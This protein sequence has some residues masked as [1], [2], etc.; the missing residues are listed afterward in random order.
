[1]WTVWKGTGFELRVAELF[2][3]KGYRVTHNVRMTGRSGA[4]HHIGT[5][6]QFEAPLHTSTVIV[7]AKSHAL[8]VSKAAVTDLIHVQQDLSADRAVFATTGGFT[9]GATQT[10]RQYQN[11]EL[12]DGAKMTSVLGTARPDADAGGGQVQAGSA[13]MVR[14]EVTPEEMQRHVDEVAEKRSRR[15]EVGE[16]AMAVTKFLYPY[17]D[18]GA[19]VKVR[20]TESTGW[21]SSE[22]V[23]STVSRRIGVDAR[24]GSIIQVADDGI[25]Y[26]YFY[27]SRLSGDEIR[28]LRSVAKGKEFE[29]GDLSTIGWTA[30][31]RNKAIRGLAERGLLA[32][33]E[34][35]TYVTRAEYP[36]DPSGFEGLADRHQVTEATADDRKLEASHTPADVGTM[37]EGLWP[38]V[39]VR[40]VDLVYYP[41]YM[42]AYERS[43]CST[44]CEIRDG[45]C[46]ER[47]EYLEESVSEDEVRGGDG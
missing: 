17:Y 25:S 20:R 19:D 6:A 36:S 24:M 15:G 34:W 8:N 4:V 29:K 43:D 38:G 33:T 32:G 39:R 11:V 10:A 47:N 13:M 22:E 18:V 27:L 14:F 7:E 42:A 1:M 44:R 37:I 16:R 40:A 30:Q 26:R 31:R 45:V 28:I 46:G 21:F 35:D 23:V 12:W 2:R 3:R 41:Y 9:S 5:L